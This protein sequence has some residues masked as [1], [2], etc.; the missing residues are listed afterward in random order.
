MGA[1]VT[2]AGARGKTDAPAALE[3]AEAEIDILEPNWMKTLVET[4][5]GVE[6]GAADEQHGAGG[7]IDVA[8]GVERLAEQTVPAVYPVPGK[9]AVQSQNLGAE[10]GGGGETADEEALLRAAGGVEQEAA[11]GTDGGVG[12]LGGEASGTGF[13]DAIGIE[14]EDERGAGVAEALVDAAGEAKIAAGPDEAHVGESGDDGSGR[15]TGAVVDDDDFGE[16]ESR[17][18]GTDFRGGFIGDDDGGNHG[19]FA[20]VA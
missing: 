4:A 18:T 9:K 20:I 8:G 7:L 1:G 5:H 2:G 16:I 10:S 13:E 6:G 3:E 11:S 15:R 19:A 12:E 14:D 17:E